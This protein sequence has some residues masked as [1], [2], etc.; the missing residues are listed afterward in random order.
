MA[1]RKTANSA[2]DH[3]RSTHFANIEDS[4]MAEISKLS[5]GQALDKLRNADVSKSKI[6]RLD[7]KIEALD[8]EAQRLRAARGQLERDQRAGSARRD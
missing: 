8:Q 5:V 4:T 2:I 3:L 6:T 1:Q 7:E